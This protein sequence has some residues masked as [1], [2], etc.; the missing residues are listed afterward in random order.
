MAPRVTRLA[1]EARN[2]MVA[3]TSSTL[4]QSS[5]LALGMAARASGFAAFMLFA[6]M[7]AHGRL[8][9]ECGGLSGARGGRHRRHRRARPG[10]GRG[11]AG[12]GRALPRALYPRA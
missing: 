5:N 10:G 2:A 11:A 1:G 8:S 12:A 6:R 9:H 3:A 4:G 7:A